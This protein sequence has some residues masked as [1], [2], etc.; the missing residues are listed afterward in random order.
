MLSCLTDALPGL[1]SRMTQLLN[2]GVCN[3][4]DD[5][6]TR[7]VKRRI[8]WTCFII[9]TWASSG[10]NVSRQFRQQAN[11]PRA[12]MDEYVFLALFLLLRALKVY[13]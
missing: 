5:G 9:D 4:D 3:E 6:P 8:Y 7:E 11:H 2:L 10:S 13:A 12:P 1:A